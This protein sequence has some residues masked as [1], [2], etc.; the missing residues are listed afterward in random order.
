MFELLCL[1]IHSVLSLI[2]TLTQFSSNEA[3][4]MFSL[5]E[6]GSLKQTLLTLLKLSESSSMVSC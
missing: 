6:K 5:S 2:K 1:N 4:K 3:M